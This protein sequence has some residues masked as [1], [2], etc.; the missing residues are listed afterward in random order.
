MST[1]FASSDRKSRGIRCAGE[2][3]VLEEERKMR[4]SS[5]KAALAAPLVAGLLAGCG[6][7][8]DKPPPP[9]E[10]IVV[11]GETET[12]MKMTVQTFVS[13]SED[14][15]VRKLDAYRAEGGYPA[16]DYHRITADNSA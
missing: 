3:R 5:V 15:M 16:V 6:G 8:D 2:P 11:R 10:G 7:G 9:A 14:P 13:P 12:G 4:I 1:A